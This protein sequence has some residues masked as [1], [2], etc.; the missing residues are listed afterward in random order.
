MKIY[1]ISK[2]GPEWSE[3]VEAHACGKKKA[4][5]RAKELDEK[6]KSSSHPLDILSSHTVTPMEL[7]GLKTDNMFPSPTFR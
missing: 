5:K 2:T 3:P 1:L 6:L 4:Y 7:Q